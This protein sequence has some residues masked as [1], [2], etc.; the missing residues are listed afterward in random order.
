MKRSWRNNALKFCQIAGLPVLEPF[1]RL[2]AGE[3]VRE[4]FRQIGKY[5]VVPV[6]AMLLLI[7]LW[8]I[9]AGKIKTD[10]AQLPSP[11]ATWTAAKELWN[12][13]RQQRKTDALRREEER[14][15]AIAYMVQALL[16]ERQAES[17]T[18]EQRTT[19]LAN[20][21]L[22]RKQAL[23]AANFNPSSAPTFVDQ[24]LRSIGTVFVGFLIATLVAV[25]LGILCGMSPIFNAAVSPIIQL[26]KPVS[27][28]AWLPIASIVIIWWYSGSD[29]EDALFS[30][31]FLISATTVSLCSLWPTLVNTA[32]GVASV[33]PDYLNVAKVL[34][35]SWWQTL[36][37]IILPASLPLMFAGLRIS[38]GVGWMVL[39][40]A[41]MLAQNPG[42]GKFV[43]DMF[44]NGSDST[45]AKI[46]VAVLVI[47][48]VGLALDRLMVCLRNLVSF[49]NGA[50]A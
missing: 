2:A 27:P 33:N 28:L 19:L 48:L 17:A 37:K 47:G 49:E 29:P 39:I 41:D 13:H 46:A 21:A 40:A 18:D 35:L 42:L 6:L 24:T 14:E 38:L 3:D 45:Y 44:Q 32:L 1:V 9:A 11:T 5:T 22:L 15:H 12:A 36:I 50:A 10:S 16:A 20:A 7:G 31:A 4:Q 25:P 23:Q 26:F 30:R 8:S 34:R 43:W